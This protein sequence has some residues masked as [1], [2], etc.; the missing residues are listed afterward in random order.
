MALIVVEGGKSRKGDELF[1]REDLQLIKYPTEIQEIPFKY[2][3]KKIKPIPKVETNEMKEDNEEKEAED[4]KITDDPVI[5]IQGDSRPQRK[6]AP[7]DV[8][9]PNNF[10]GRRVRKKF[11]ET[12]YIGNIT[13]FDK[14]YFQ[15]LYE[16]GDEEELNL[17]QVKRFLIHEDT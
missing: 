14:P 13:G 6:A 8:N 15:I 3:K 10:I 16:D 1:L 9:N 7:Q 12:F 2:R 4:V 5:G 17:N 11:G